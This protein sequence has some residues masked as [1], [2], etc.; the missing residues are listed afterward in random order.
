MF[1][2]MTKEQAKKSV[3]KYLEENASDHVSFS[4]KNYQYDAEMEQFE[5]RFDVDSAVED[6]YKI[7]RSKSVINNVKTYVSLLMNT[8]NI[9]PVLIYNEKALDDY[10]D[11]L[12]ISLPEQVEE[13]R[14]L[15]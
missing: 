5:A 7:A 1:H 8:V 2:G 14:I 13:P 6:A 9:D 4:F 15:Y 11:F 10:I 12:E 3:T